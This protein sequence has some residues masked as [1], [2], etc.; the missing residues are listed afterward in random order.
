MWAS[1]VQLF[2]PNL[3]RISGN[4]NK[5]IT[6]HEVFKAKIK[7]FRGGLKQIPVYFLAKRTVEK[8]NLLN[9]NPNTTESAKAIKSSKI[10]KLKLSKPKKHTAHKYHSRMKISSV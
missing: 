2:L 4:P 7:G 8:K 3:V 5:K 1:K 10:P 9:T 6:N